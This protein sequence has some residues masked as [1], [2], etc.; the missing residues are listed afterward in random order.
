VKILDL[1]GRQDTGLVGHGEI[2][3]IFELFNPE[4]FKD[5]DFD[6][7]EDLIYYM[8]NQPEFYRK[9]Y[10]PMMIKFKKHHEC[11]KQV[12]P[13]AFIPLVKNAFEMYANEFP[14]ETIRDGLKTEM[15]EE[16]C[17]EIHKI[18][19]ENIK[20]GHYDGK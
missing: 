9:Q 10:Y 13:K 15:C 7:K 19:L 3:K 12:N 18:E 11:G 6:V 2:M 1:V 8:N 16:I 20:N 5:G 14:V 4:K 17:A